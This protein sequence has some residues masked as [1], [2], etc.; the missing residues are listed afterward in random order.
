MNVYAKISEEA[1]AEFDE[2]GVSVPAYLC[3]QDAPILSD[4]EMKQVI[5][6]YVEVPVEHIT[7]ITEEEYTTNIGEEVEFE[8]KSGCCG[9]CSDCTCGTD[10][11]CKDGCC[12]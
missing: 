4:S 5:S 12:G 8:K 2:N 1:S 6:D 3:V 7:L 9:G 11:D 10:D